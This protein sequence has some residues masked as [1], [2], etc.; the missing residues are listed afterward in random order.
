MH[1]SHSHT[2]II[3]QKTINPFSVSRIL[4]M[5]FYT[6]T[7]ITREINTSN[8]I[9]EMMMMM[10]TA[11]NDRA[12]GRLHG[13]SERIWFLGCMEGEVAALHGQCGRSADSPAECLENPGV[14]SQ[15]NH[16]PSRPPCAALTMTSER[17]AIKAER[18]V[19]NISRCNQ[20][21][22]LINKSQRFCLVC[23]YS[24]STKIKPAF[25]CRGPTCV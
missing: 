2:I 23:V 12:A 25:E 8:T 17:N 5:W 1:R 4:W 9:A 6:T 19:Q 15:A 7:N 14:A 18:F 16:C 21:S 3:K 24:C 11:N 22:A 20:T 13:C 10:M